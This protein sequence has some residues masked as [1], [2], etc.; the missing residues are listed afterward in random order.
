[1]MTDDVG[2]WPDLVE[3]IRTMQGKTGGKRSTLKRSTW[4]AWRNRTN[5][6]PG[7]R[8]L[9]LSNVLPSCRTDCA[10]KDAPAV[11]SPSRIFDGTCTKH[12]QVP[13]RHTDRLPVERLLNESSLVC[14]EEGVCWTRTSGRTGSDVDT[15]PLSSDAV[16]V[17]REDT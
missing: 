13:S 2:R 8:P 6:T 1:M 11:L 17:V 14:V 10:E 4:P 7:F 15:A 16:I 12:A 5:A 3:G 9:R